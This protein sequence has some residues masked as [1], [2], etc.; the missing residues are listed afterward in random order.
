MYV[1]FSLIPREERFFC[2]NIV[3]ARRER[4]VRLFVRHPALKQ[5]FALDTD[6]LCDNLCTRQIHEKL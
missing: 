6:E 4:S 5:N 3:C 2:K 1:F